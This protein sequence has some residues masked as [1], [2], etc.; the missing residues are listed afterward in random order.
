MDLLGLRRLGRDLAQARLSSV[1]SCLFW[2]VL[3]IH[4]LVSWRSF[5]LA[6]GRSSLPLMAQGY[7]AHSLG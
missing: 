5:L 2:G 4:L 7:Q 6:S 3:L 1:F